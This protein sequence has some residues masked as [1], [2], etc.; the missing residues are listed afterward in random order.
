MRLFGVDVAQTACNHNR[1]VETAHRVAMFHLKRAEIAQQ[2]RA[3]KFII[4]RRATQWRVNHNIQ[5]R[6]NVFRLAIIALPRLPEIRNIQIRNRETCQT[7][8]RTRTTPRCA[9][10]TNFAACA[11]C[12]ARKWCDGGW[13]IM[14]F[15]FHDDVCIFMMKIILLGILC[16]W[17][18]TLNFCAFN[19]R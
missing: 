12:C 1:F 7:C 4:K 15:Y 6:S 13:V 16:I 2:I 8:F 17:I 18:Q 14:G 3:T 11:C 10:I 9:F 19:H 5:R